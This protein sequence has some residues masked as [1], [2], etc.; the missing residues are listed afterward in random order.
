MTEKEYLQSAYLLNELIES[1]QREL[2]ALHE[3]ST[4]LQS[5][6]TSKDRVARSRDGSASF[7]KI[8][9]KIA[10][11]EAEINKEIDHYVDLKKE[12]HRGIEDVTDMKEKM[13]LR[14]RYIEFMTWESIAEKTHYSESQL[15]RIH[16]GA[17]KHIKIPENTI[18]NDPKWS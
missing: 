2:D 5:Q 18:Q 14:Y 16:K 12:I 13:C 3:L 11:L 15:K 6:D 7:T 17:L 8:V 10:D 9:D 4:S 1:E